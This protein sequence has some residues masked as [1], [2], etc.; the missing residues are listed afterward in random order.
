MEEVVLPLMLVFSLT[1]KGKRV[2]AGWPTRKSRGGV[3]GWD[4]KTAWQWQGGRQMCG[5]DHY[6]WW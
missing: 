4:V 1:Y 3:L 5:I 6:F 2:R